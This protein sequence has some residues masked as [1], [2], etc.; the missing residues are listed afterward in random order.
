MDT[1][2]LSIITVCFNASKSIGETMESVADLAFRDIEHLI[3][4]G[5]STDDTLSV[6]ERFRNPT[7]RVVSEKDSGIYDAMNKGLAMSR[8]EFVLFLNAGDSIADRDFLNRL[9]WEDDFY[10]GGVVIRAGD[11][12]V[13]RDM[14]AVFFPPIRSLF[15]QIACHQCMLVRKTHSPPYNLRY[16]LTADLDWSIRILRRPGL[17][18]KRVESYWV[19]Y[20]LDGLSTRNADR[21]WDERIVIIRAHFGA[22]TVPVSRVVRA[23]YA[24]KAIARAIL[25]R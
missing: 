6:V 17:R 15:S 8:G 24:S 7:T 9:T 23:W 10:Y 14:P 5:K 18:K 11:K 16:R 2:R 21:C 13:K 12:V 19:N 3:I 22:W 25:K 4:D 1:P 20:E